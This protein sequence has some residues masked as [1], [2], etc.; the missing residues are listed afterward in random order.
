MRVFVAGATGAMG[1]TLLPR[2][3]AAGHEVTGMSRSEERAQALRASGVDAIVCDAFDRE[4]LAVALAAARPEVVVHQLTDI[5]QAIDMRR[6]AEQFEGNDRLRVEGTRNLVDAALAAGARRMVAQSI[7]FVYDFSGTGLKT[8]DDRLFDDAP[9]PF[10]RGVA[11]VRSLA[12]AV[13]ETEGLEGLVLRYGYFYGPGTAYA[14]DGFIAELARKRR[15]P[16]VGRGTGV[17]SMIH[18]DDGADAAVAAVETRAT[19]IFNVVDDDPAPGREL[20]PAFAAAVGA[21][22]PRRIPR[23]LAGLIVGRAFARTQTDQKGASNARAKAELDWAPAHP[24]WREG[25]TEL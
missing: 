20:V 23:W 21:P 3:R 1:R 17:Y 9:P 7:A 15:L 2:L 18:V 22:K 10:G 6:Y 8:E 16:I 12:R 11:A 5:P 19:G 4:G 24:S 13:T 25:F 14:R